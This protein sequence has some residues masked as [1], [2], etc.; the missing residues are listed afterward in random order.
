MVSNP[1]FRILK[2]SGIGSDGA[3]DVDV[4]DDDVL[5]AKI[6]GSTPET[7]KYH[8]ASQ[9]FS[10]ILDEEEDLSDCSDDGGGGGVLVGKKAALFLD[11][12]L[13]G[14]SEEY[15]DESYLKVL[16]ADTEET[17]DDLDAMMDGDD[18]DTVMAALKEQAYAEATEV[19]RSEYDRASSS[20]VANPAVS[21]LE[22]GRASSANAYDR[23]SS[24]VVNPVVLK[25]A[26]NPKLPGDANY[27]PGFAVTKRAKKKIFGIDDTEADGA[28]SLSSDGAYE[29][30]ESALHGFRASDAA[31]DNGLKRAVNLNCF[32]QSS[33]SDYESTE[34]ALDGFRTSDNA[35]ERRLSKTLF[36][37][38]PDAVYDNSGARVRPGFTADVRESEVVAFDV[39][40]A[41]WSRSVPASTD[42][43][44]AADAAAVDDAD[45]ETDNSSSDED[46]LYTDIAEVENI[47]ASRHAVGGIYGGVEEIGNAS[48]SSIYEGFG[49]DPLAAG[50]E[51]YA[52][53]PEAGGISL[54]SFGE[55]DTQ[56]SVEPIYAE[57]GSNIVGGVGGDL[58]PTAGRVCSAIAD[59]KEIYVDTPEVGN[60]SAISTYEG[61]DNHGE[62]ILPTR[63]Q[64]DLSGGGGGVAVSSATGEQAAVVSVIAKPTDLYADTPEVGNLSVTSTYA[65]LGELV[66]LAN[67]MLDGVVV[68]AASTAGVVAAVPI[69]APSSLV[70][71]VAKD[72]VLSSLD[73][74]LYADSLEVGNTS[75]ASNYDGFEDEPMP[76]AAESAYDSMPMLQTAV[77]STS[78]KDDI[79][80]NTPE[81]GCAS[82][83]SIYGGFEDQTT[84]VESDSD[85][86]APLAVVAPLSIAAADESDYDTVLPPHAGPTPYS[87][88]VGGVMYSN[89]ETRAICGSGLLMNTSPEDLDDD[90]DYENLDYEDIPDYTASPSKPPSP[91]DDY[92][93]FSAASRTKLDLADDGAY[94]EVSWGD[95]GAVGPLQT[96]IKS[97][98]LN[99]GPLYADMAEVGN[100]SIAS[101]Y[102]GVEPTHDPWAAADSQY[103]H[104]QETGHVS[105][106]SESTYE[107]APDRVARS[108]SPV[109]SRLYAEV[110][111]LNVAIANDCDGFGEE[112]GADYATMPSPTALNVSDDEY[113][114]AST[115]GLNGRPAE[116]FS[117]QVYSGGVFVHDAGGGDGT[118]RVD[119]D[120]V[121]LDADAGPM[122]PMLP[123]ATTTVGKASTVPDRPAAVFFESIDDKA[124]EVADLAADGA[125]GD[126]SATSM[127]V[128]G[129]L[130]TVRSRLSKLAPTSISIGRQDNEDSG[131]DS[132]FC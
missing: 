91:L 50:M 124:D 19:P 8:R 36:R 71:G 6:F 41:D 70:N 67:S 53:T 49:V 47:R 1:T 23:A 106:Q 84:A 120:A 34:S 128:F 110:S 32:N 105:A 73:L 27:I 3:H 115:G 113:V 5:D 42:L 43:V 87:V 89:A 51:L 94:E 2:L 79:Y 72:T 68:T 117:G 54:V 26:P 131:S 44:T 69:I 63:M 66:S 65:G 14:D 64:D 4:D 116:A 18:Y 108:F 62:P 39:P 104:V 92:A 56:A 78:D 13:I 61:F 109:D 48:V 98:G 22:Y 129:S 45:T 130:G 122:P 114:L 9:K 24:S 25:P 37:P 46:S 15:E 132:D 83:T 99:S 96:S 95:H 16:G 60:L 100:A 112:T 93:L 118:V 123:T 88:P 28:F 31:A 29:R 21:E 30:T 126:Q 38:S 75:I 82:V 86:V 90:L 77:V 101:N 35:A 58:L 81:V 10:A 102:D 121:Y 125:S 119:S 103:E 52:E 76:A 33:G 107:V 85:S 17:F 55:F 12:P 97:S 57:V 20:V 80:A 11:N 7:S 59:P 40:V 127:S 111:D 74:G